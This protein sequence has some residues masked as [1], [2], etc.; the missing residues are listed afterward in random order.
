MA[1][2]VE[3]NF[4]CTNEPNFELLLSFICKHAKTDIHSRTIEVMDDWEYK[5]SYK[6]KSIKNLI[7]LPD[8]KIVRIM[9]DGKYGCAGIDTEKIGNKFCVMI[10]F[11]LEKYSP[12]NNYSKLLKKTVEFPF[13]KFRRLLYILHF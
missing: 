10:W 5:N 8:K 7:N 3:I 2:V 9:E 4:I 12:L 11:N 1:E 6:V 13:Q